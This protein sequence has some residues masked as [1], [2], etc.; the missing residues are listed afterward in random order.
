MLSVMRNVVSAANAKKAFCIDA[1]GFFKL[2]RDD[3]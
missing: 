2:D 3:I 1:E